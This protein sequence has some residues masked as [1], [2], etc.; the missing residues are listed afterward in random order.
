MEVICYQKIQTYSD[1]KFHKDVIY[2]Y[3]YIYIS[4]SR[5]LCAD[6][7]FTI[8]HF[9]VVSLS[10]AFSLEQC[11]HVIFRSSMYLKQYNHNYSFYIVILSLTSLKNIH[12]TSQHL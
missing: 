5:V 6:E 12:V 11:C 8:V 4:F 7:S 1:V 3:I 2:I 9:A 10:S